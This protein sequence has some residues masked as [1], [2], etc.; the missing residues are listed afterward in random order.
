VYHSGVPFRSDLFVCLTLVS[1][2]VYHSGVLLRS[3]L[4]GCRSI[5]GQGG[6]S[7]RSSSPLCLLCLP[8]HLSQWCIRAEFFTASSS[9]QV[10]IGC[11]WKPVVLERSC[12]PLRSVSKTQVWQR[13]RV[14]CC[15]QRCRVSYIVVARIVAQQQCHSNCIRVRWMMD[16][17]PPKRP[18]L[19]QDVDLRMALHTGRISMAGLRTK[20]TTSCV[21]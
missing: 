9:L 4:C 16:G 14:T 21:Q 20:A 15:W 13:C 19:Q 10:P 17:R 12:S 6:V 18:R 11:F 2:V 8:F 7:Q 1:E 3:D 5:C